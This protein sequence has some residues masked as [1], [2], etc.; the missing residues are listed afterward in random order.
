MLRKRRKLMKRRPLLPRLTE[1]AR[2]AT[3]ATGARETK[4]RRTPSL[5]SVTKA[6]DLRVARI[7]PT[8]AMFSSAVHP[9]T[10]TTLAEKCHATHTLATEEASTEEAEEAELTSRREVR[11]MTVPTTVAMAPPTKL[12]TATGTCLTTEEETTSTSL[13][14]TG[15][16]IAGAVSMTSPDQATILLPE[17]QSD[18]LSANPCPPTTSH[19]REGTATSSLR[20]TTESLKHGETDPV[21]TVV[22]AFENALLHALV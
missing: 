1:A 2:D 22:R 9:L 4:P 14:M 12:A 16:A 20:S 8:L 10:S 19:P 15:R 6:T 21:Q 7:V 17:D 11:T 3:V 5:L 13:S 18:L